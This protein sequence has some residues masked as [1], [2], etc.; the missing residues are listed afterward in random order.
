MAV[1]SHSTR[2]QS[3]S[4]SGYHGKP[5]RGT[6]TIREFNREQRM[7]RAL[8]ELVIVGLPTSQPF[9]LRV[10]DDPEFL[11]GQIDIKYLERAG[12]R[13]LAAPPRPGLERALAVAAAMVADA[14]RERPPQGLLTARPSQLGSWIDTARREALRDGLE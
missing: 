13:V 11:K 3:F 8:N 6:V 9:H 12:A 14:R 1:R 5:T 10:M 2:V 4:L 7:R